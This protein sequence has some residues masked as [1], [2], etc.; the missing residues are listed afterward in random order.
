MLVGCCED[1]KDGCKF[2]FKDIEVNF[3]FNLFFVLG[4]C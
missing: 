3:C 4:V 1:I 2:K